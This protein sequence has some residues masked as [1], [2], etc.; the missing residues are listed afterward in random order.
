MIYLKLKTN[1]NCLAKMIHNWSFTDVNALYDKSVINIKIKLRW[2][3]I[4]GWG[5]L[6]FND[7]FLE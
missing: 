4:E 6:K 1:D 2:I 7:F 3:I 5:E